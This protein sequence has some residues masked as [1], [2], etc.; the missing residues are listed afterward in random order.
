MNNKANYYD[1]LRILSILVIILLHI[2]SLPRYKYF[3]TNNLYFGIITFIDS[4]TRFGVPIFF[5]LT[6]ALMFDKK[7]EI[8]DYKNYLKARVCKLLFPYLAFCVVYLVGDW[9]LSSSPFS[10]LDFLTRTTAG[11]MQYHLWFMPVIIMIYVMLPFIKRLI[12]NLDKKE[13]EILILGI[14]IFGN[15]FQAIY[16]LSFVYNHK[17][18]EAFALPNIIVYMNYLFMGYYLKKEDIKID[19]K[20]VIASIISFLCI[21]PASMIIS[22][23]EITDFF[24][25]S[26]SLFV[27]L[28]SIL[29]FLLFKN[30]KKKTGKK[31]SKFLISQRKTIFYVYLVHPLIIKTFGY[32]LGDVFEKTKLLGDFLFVT[33]YFLGTTILSFLIANGIVWI[34]NW[35][36]KH[37]ETI[38]KV[39]I[40]IFYFV[41]GCILV[42]IEINFIGNFYHFSKINYF[43]L[44]VGL[45][46][47]V[48][49]FYFL[50]KKQETVFQYK[51]LNIILLILYLGL[52]IGILYFFAVK[53]SWDFGQVYD[54]AVRYA[55]GKGVPT[56]EGYLYMCDNNIAIAT[57]LSLLFKGFSLIGIKNHFLEIGLG[58]NLLCV[59]VSHLFTY[60]TI[61]K[62]NEKYSKP[63]LV[64]ILLFTPLLFYLPI[65]YSD[66]LTLPFLA[67]ALY[68]LY[69]YL[70]IKPKI[71]Y[72][73]I[74]GLLIG[75]GGLVKPTILILVVA[76]IICCILRPNK[77][78]DYYV[79][80]PVLLLS[81]SLPFLGYKWYVNEYFDEGKLYEKSLPV[82]H[83]LM[84]GLKGNGGFNGEDYDAIVLI[85][86]K[87]NKKKVCNKNIKERLEEH[88]KKKDFLSFYNNKISYT[89]A[90]SSYFA[91]EKLKRE[92]I[93]PEMTKYISSNTG[94]DRL[95]WA[96][97]NTEWFLLL[98]CI[99]LGC[100]NHKY[101]LREEQDYHLI[102]TLSIFGLFLFLLIW[103]TRSRYILNFS[104]IFLVSGYLGLVATINSHKQ[105]KGR[106][107]KK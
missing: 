96:V 49:F 12:D 90:D 45:I 81:I 50:F 11:T 39:L 62:C 51:I 28:P 95:F 71:H 102:I 106:S 43:D 73:I 98:G 41:M 105:K 99:F 86:G 25:D 44:I 65:F 19:K 75:I 35:I 36:I 3:Q 32:F 104:P 59:N 78:I 87:D 40:T 1:K 66:T 5:M 22:R 34:K 63:Y 10:L 89:W 27:I 8:K 74:T 52:Q 16:H 2:L 13:L 17:L 20:L 83:F 107:A 21:T 55:L 77:K 103:E 15:I 60:L 46:L 56:I 68:T 84:I 30:S 80:I 97:S 18:L 93:H 42:L 6:G 33:L 54:I 26:M 70:F 24:L 101:L 48:V 91:T 72:I 67:I 57:A 29:V 9:V 94:E 23:T 47:G 88:W 79:M 92:P 7:I 61:R 4:F 64:F 14:F 53:P 76:C 58:L 100:L 38:S 69:N 85:D 82:N 31:M 37:K